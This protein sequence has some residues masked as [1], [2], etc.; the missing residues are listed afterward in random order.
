MSAKTLEAAAPPTNGKT[1]EAPGKAAD[2]VSA[3]ASEAKF[4]EGEE[5]AIA[6]AMGFEAPKAADAPAAPKKEAEAGDDEVRSES[7][8]ADDA[9]DKGEESAESGKEPGEESNEAEPESDADWQECL[10]LAKGDHK[11]ALKIASVMFGVEDGTAAQ[12]EAPAAKAKRR[13]T[14]ELVAE[15]YASAKGDD[16]Q[17]EAKALAKLLE[18]ERE[19]N[20]AEREADL[21]ALRTQAKAEVQA[22]QD[23]RALAKAFPKWAQDKDAIKAHYAVLAREEGRGALDRPPL[24]VYRDLLQRRSERK[25]SAAATKAA[26]EKVAAEKTAREAAAAGGVPGGRPV[27]PTDRKHLSTLGHEMNAFNAMRFGRRSLP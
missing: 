11:K 22:E 1:S 5:A 8:S 20:K 10:R 6:A 12:P 19:A 15:F 24:S 27:G 9:G 18:A 13:P 21:E 16:P 23:I 25:G 7:E 2:P 4:A 14:E 26:A 17:A 3:P